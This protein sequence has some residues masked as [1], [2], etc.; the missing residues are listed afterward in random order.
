MYVKLGTALN[1]YDDYLVVDFSVKC[2]SGAC[3][4]ENSVGY[5][6]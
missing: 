6:V 3:D 2:P 1:V 4:T 5:R